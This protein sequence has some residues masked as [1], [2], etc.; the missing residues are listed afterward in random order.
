LIGVWEA[1]E[2]TVPFSAGMTMSKGGLLEAA[3]HCGGGVWISVPSVSLGTGGLT[4]PCIID[5]TTASALWRIHVSEAQLICGIS[6]YFTTSIV[7]FTAL[8]DSAEVWAPLAQ[9]SRHN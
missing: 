7:G 2:A 3:V 1:K 5:A 6:I 4:E 9:F 8:F